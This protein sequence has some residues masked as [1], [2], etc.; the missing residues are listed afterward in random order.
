MSELFLTRQFSVFKLIQP[1]KTNQRSHQM[2]HIL[3]HV[4]IIATRQ[5]RATRPLGTTDRN[6]NDTRRKAWA[7]STGIRF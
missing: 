6:E 3:A 5:D 4:L 7:D 1:D 2:L